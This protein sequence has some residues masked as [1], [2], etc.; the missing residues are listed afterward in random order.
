MKKYKWERLKALAI[1]NLQ[2]RLHGGCFTDAHYHALFPA[3]I[4]SIEEGTHK[5]VFDIIDEWTAKAIAIIDAWDIRK[6]RKLLEAFP[7]IGPKNYTTIEC[8]YDEDGDWA[9]YI[10]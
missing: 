6:A 7:A 10:S 9:V 2:Y 4:A 8:D 1:R 5:S 3:V